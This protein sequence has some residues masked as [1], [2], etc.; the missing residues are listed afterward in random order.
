MKEQANRVQN[1]NIDFEMKAHDNL[2][3][4]IKNKLTIIDQLT[5]TDI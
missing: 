5:W 4:N 2:V 1:K 3:E